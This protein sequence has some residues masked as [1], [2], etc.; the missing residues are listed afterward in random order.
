M[1]ERDDPDDHDLLAPAY[2]DEYLDLYHLAIDHY[3]DARYN[4][5]HDYSAG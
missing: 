2:D 5:D 4:D 3:N 1:P